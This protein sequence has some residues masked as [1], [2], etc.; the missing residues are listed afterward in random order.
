VNDPSQVIKGVVVT[1]KSERLKAEENKYTFR[2]APGA[3][4]IE[5]RRAVEVMFKVHVTD[6]KVMNFMGKVRRMGMFSGRR[7]SWRKAIV[8]VK[9]GESI[10]A[11]ER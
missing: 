8:R 11:L 2:V 5:I 3:N 9:P 7:A 1:E 6:V 10:E 4:K